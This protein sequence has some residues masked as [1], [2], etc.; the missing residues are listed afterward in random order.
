MCKGEYWIELAP[1]SDSVILASVT[2]L[3]FFIYGSE[4]YNFI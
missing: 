1:V 3:Q 4:S 2:G